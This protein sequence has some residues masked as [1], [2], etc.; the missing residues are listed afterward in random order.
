MGQGEE[1]GLCSYF[2][3]DCSCAAREIAAGDSMF[4]RRS[5][6]MASL[7][8]FPWSIKLIS[9]LPSRYVLLHFLLYSAESQSDLI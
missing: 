3:F 6:F 9:D 1:V 2:W 5:H 4:C 8:Q 7:H